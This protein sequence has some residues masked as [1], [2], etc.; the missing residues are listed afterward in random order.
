MYCSNGYQG[1]Q[2]ATSHLILEAITTIKHELR[3]GKRVTFWTSDRPPGRARRATLAYSTTDETPNVIAAPDFIFWNWP[4]V[5]VDDYERTRDRIIAAGERTAEDPRMFWIGNVATSPYRAR[6]MDVAASEPRILATSLDWVKRDRPESW[7][8]DTLM[9]TRQGNY[10][11][12][13]D[14]CAYRYLLDVEGAGYSGRVKLL[15]LTGRPLFL[16]DRPWREWYFDRLEPFRHFIPVR[17]DLSDLSARLDW[18][19]AHPEECEAIATRAQEFARRELTREA[20]V[21]HLR[22]ILRDVLA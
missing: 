2:E 10:V 17:R 18:A 14:H 20:A 19:E 4:E 7:A 22:A 15:L 3:A 11:S 16:Q 9:G 5:G 1:R 6:L 8:S 13:E 12:L 21:G